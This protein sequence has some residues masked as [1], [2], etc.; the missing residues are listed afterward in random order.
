MLDVP[1]LT[2]FHGFDAS[3]YPQSMKRR[4]KYQRLFLQGDFFAV[5]SEAIKK[6]LIKLGCPP[7]KIEVCYLGVE[8]NQFPY[9]PRI[10]DNGPI[11]LVSVG[12]LVK[13]ERSSCTHPGT[14]IGE[15][16]IS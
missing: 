11:Q 7:N 10:L 9:V 2:F 16:R 4:S 14:R 6:Q 5:P 3:Q 1:V 13:K 12:R 8:L 15:R